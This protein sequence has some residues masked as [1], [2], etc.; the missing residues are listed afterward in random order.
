MTDNKKTMFN[1]A[2]VFIKDI[3]FLSQTYFD[4]KPLNFYNKKVF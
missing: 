3:W 4:G 1:I 2:L